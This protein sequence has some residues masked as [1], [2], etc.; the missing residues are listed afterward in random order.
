MAHACK[1]VAVKTLS[2]IKAAPIELSDHEDADNDDYVDDFNDDAV[3]IADSD[4]AAQ[5]IS[6][7]PPTLNSQSQEDD[8]EFVEQFLSTTTTPKP[9]QKRSFFS[10]FFSMGQVSFSTAKPTLNI[11][12]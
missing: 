4:F 1:N 11:A 5:V 8:R 6:S 3:S 10:S 9:V 12:F 7:S 2:T